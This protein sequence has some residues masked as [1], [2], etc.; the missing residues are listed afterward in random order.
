MHRIASA[1]FSGQSA[2][3]ASSWTGGE[4]IGS[5]FRQPPRLDR[6][7]R[8]RIGVARLEGQVRKGARE[9]QRMLAAAA[10]DFEHQPA[11]GKDVAQHIDD[12]LRIA[13]D[14]RR[15]PPPV[16]LAGH[17]DEGLRTRHSAAVACSGAL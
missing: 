3:L 7:E 1:W 4:Q 17:Q 16:T 10:G 9:V 14:M 8:D 5:P 13:R 2:A 12:G 11:R 6:R 15:N